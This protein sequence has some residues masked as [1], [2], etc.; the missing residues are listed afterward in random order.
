VKS[1]WKTAILSQRIL[2]ALLIVMFSGLSPGYLNAQEEIK[3]EGPDG[4]EFWAIGSVQN[5]LWHTANYS[6][7]VRIEC[8]TDAGASYTII[9]SSYSGT[10]PCEW[11]ILHAP[12]EL[13]AIKIADPADYDPFDISDAVFAIAA[14]DP[15]TPA[16]QDV[17]VDLG[18]GHG[19]LFQQ[20]LQAGNSE[21]LISE[22][23]PPP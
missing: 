1:L 14:D 13:C 3:V 7:P 20:V 6:G 11:T 22:E 2:C 9:D 19:I 17:M 21:L 8:A 16:G 10:A 5:I 15:N 18:D 4:N 12:S 23:G